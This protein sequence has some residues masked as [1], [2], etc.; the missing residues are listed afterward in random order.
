MNGNHDFGT[1][2]LALLLSLIARFNH[3]G[4]SRITSASSRRRYRGA[5]RAGLAE[6]TWLI[7]EG[8]RAWAAARLMRTRYVAI[9]AAEDAFKINLPL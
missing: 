1:Q 4:L 8:R 7:S 6:V 3:G 9:V 2:C 5:L